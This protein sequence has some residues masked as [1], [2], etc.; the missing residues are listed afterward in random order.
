MDSY[1]D[2]MRR[3]L[4]KPKNNPKQYWYSTCTSNIVFTYCEDISKKQR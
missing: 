1:Y 3:A 4:R 2:A